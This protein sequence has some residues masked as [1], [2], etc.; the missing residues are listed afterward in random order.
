MIALGLVLGSL[1][2]EI[3]T[4]HETSPIGALTA[5]GCTV[6]TIG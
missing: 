1:A 4:M 3:E 2:I 5:V 6:D